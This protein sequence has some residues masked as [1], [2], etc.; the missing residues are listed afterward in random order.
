MLHML[1]RYTCISVVVYFNSMFASVYL[2][3]SDGRWLTEL[4]AFTEKKNM[5]GAIQI[6][7]PLKHSPRHH[8]HHLML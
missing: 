1:A 6:L 7:D 3:C 2:G 8:N 4:G 5:N